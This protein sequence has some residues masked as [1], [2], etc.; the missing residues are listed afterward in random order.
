MPARIQAFCRDTGQ[1][2]PESR[3]EIVRCILESL[4]LE[5]RAVAEQV[6]TLAGRRPRVIHVVG[7]GSQNWL[8]NQF[9]A[10]AT[11][12][13]VVAGPVE[14]TATG[15]LL[16]QMM[17]LGELA[18]IADGRALVRRSFSLE[19]YQPSDTGAWDEAY[20]R[21]RSLKVAGER[22]D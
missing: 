17:A 14:A 4:A 18:S 8:L 15:N 10:D 21:Y 6:Q 19:T 11:G 9:T 16:V 3:G 22:S 1:P 20:E 2:V 5:Y 12:R 13:P 7:G